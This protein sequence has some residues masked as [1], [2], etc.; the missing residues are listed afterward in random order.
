[1]AG[2]ILAKSSIKDVQCTYVL[3]NIMPSVHKEIYACAFSK[4]CKDFA[5]KSIVRKTLFYPVLHW[6]E[7]IC[8]ERKHV[9]MF[10]CSN[11]NNFLKANYHIKN[12]LKCYNNNPDNQER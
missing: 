8:E 1:M 2:R 6:I 5:H 4:H 10:L 7:K 12:Y 9:R 3:G 11:S